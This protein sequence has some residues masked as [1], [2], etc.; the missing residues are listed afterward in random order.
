MESKLET[1][2]KIDIGTRVIGILL[3][4][5][6]IAVVSWMAYEKHVNNQILW[7]TP[8]D[9]QKEVDRSYNRE[10]G[11]ISEK[12]N[13]LKTSVDGLKDL[14]NALSELNGKFTKLEDILKLMNMEEYAKKLGEMSGELASTKKQWEHIFQTSTGEFVRKGE[15]GFSKWE[16]EV[17]QVNLKNAES[18]IKDLEHQFEEVNKRLL[19]LGAEPIQIPEEDTPEEEKVPL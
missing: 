19:E 9:R 4:L 13:E 14:S 17:M 7:I 5:I 1:G 16:I 11:A 12:Y 18:R 10:V 8:E 15:I 6:L 2:G 3:I